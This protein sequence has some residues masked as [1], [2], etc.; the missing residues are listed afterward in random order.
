MKFTKILILTLFF[1]SAAFSVSTS[2]HRY[3]TS[4][5]R[6]DHKTENNSLEITIQLFTHDL[7][8]AIEPFRRQNKTT[9]KADENDKIILEY[10][11]RNFILKNAR[12]EVQELKWIGSET[13]VDTTYVYVE[14]FNVGSLD[15]WQL[16]NTIF[17]ENFAEQTNLVIARFGNF[18]A[19]LL[20]KSG[21]KF[22]KFELTKK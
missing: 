12:E 19:D 18:K 8:I 14:V 21:D 10:L 9:A 6:I 2:A 7:E 13:N 1:V 16:R 4:L 15:D 3:H 22:K 20:F 11:A 5:T 17:F